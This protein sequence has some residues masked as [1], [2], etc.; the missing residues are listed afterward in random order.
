[1]LCILF[2]LVIG[3]IHINEQIEFFFLGFYK[4]NRGNFVIFLPT[5]FGRMADYWRSC[6]FLVDFLEVD[7]YEVSIVYI[8]N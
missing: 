4:G 3:E 8:H 7:F 1:M 6:M 5:I 2:L